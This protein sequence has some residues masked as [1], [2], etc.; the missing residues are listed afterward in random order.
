MA[1]PLNEDFL[2]SIFAVGV[3]GSFLYIIYGNVYKMMAVQ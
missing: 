2:P 3:C 1:A